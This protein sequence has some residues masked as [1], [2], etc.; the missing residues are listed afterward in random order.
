MGISLTCTKS[1]RTMDLGANGFR[2]LRNKVAE[3]VGEPFASHYLQLSDPARFFLSG[4]ALH[5]FYDRFDEQTEVLI[6]AK[7][8]PA[9]TADF[10]LQPDLHSVCHYGACKQLLRFIGDYDDDVIYG[11]AARPN[12]AT[13]AHLKAI[14]QDCIDLKCDL[15]WD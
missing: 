11:Y 1:G 4:E 13:F 12:T 8:I 9:K 14:L 2:M 3:L 7:K 6:A 15:E 5:Q 10:L